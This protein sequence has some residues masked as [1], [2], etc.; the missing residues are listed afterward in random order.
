MAAGQLAACPFIE[1]YISIE[2]D[3]AWFGAVRNG[4]ND[5]RLS[6]HLCEP[7]EPEPPA[8]LIYLQSG[9][10][11]QWR[12]RAETDEGLFRDYVAF[13]ATLGIRFDCVLVDG[14]ARNFCLQAGWKLLRSGGLLILHDAQ[15]AEYQQTLEAIGKPVFLAPWKRGQIC[16]MLKN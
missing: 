2:H 11:N 12:M 10:R 15:R 5:P 16:L 1:R 9:K 7:A 4:I 13:P 3:R 8:P 14:R 6:L